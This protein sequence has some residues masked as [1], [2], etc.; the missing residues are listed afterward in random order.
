MRQTVLILSFFVSLCAGAQ[1]LVVPNLG[2]WDG[3]FR[4]K[5]ALSDGAVFWHDRGY[6]IQVVHPKHRGGGTPNPHYPPHQWP[7]SWP[8][9]HALFVDF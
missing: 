8:D 6:R 1:P 3:A 4:A 2:Q 5:T 7:E 9:A